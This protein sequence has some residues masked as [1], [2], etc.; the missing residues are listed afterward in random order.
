MTPFIAELVGTFLLIFLGN[1]VNANL[2]LNHTKAERSS[3]DWLFICIGWAFSVY[4][5]VVVAAPF[6]GAHLNP[7]VSFG[8]A[9]AGQ[10]EWSNLLFYVSAQ[11]LGACLGAIFVYLFYYQH[12][13]R[14]DDETLKLATF[15]TIPAIPNKLSNFF[16]EVMGAFILVFVVLFTSQLVSD[17]PQHAQLLGLGSVGALP[18]ALLILVIGMALGGTTGYAINPARDFG[19]RLIHQLLPIKGSS[20]WSYAWIPIIGPLIGGLLAASLYLGI[21]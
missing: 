17:T 5:G 2:L 9:I 7:A 13:K 8:L 4:I 3:T 11:I 14:T 20:N 1:G 12:Y 16:S 19:P 6:S 10:L 18:I 21:N 15:S